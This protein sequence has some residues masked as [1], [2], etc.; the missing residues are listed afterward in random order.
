[1]KPSQRARLLSVACLV[2]LVAFGWYAT[3]SVRPPDC[4]VAVGAFTTADGQPIGDGGARVTWEELGESA[5][6]DMVAAGT[7]EPPAARWRHW[8]G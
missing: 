7:C 5:Y 8:L 6:Q 2:A 1:M 4:K 3:R